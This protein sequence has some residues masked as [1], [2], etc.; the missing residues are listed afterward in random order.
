[1]VEIRFGSH[2]PYLLRRHVLCATSADRDISIR[3]LSYVVL[4]AKHSVVRHQREHDH[5][6]GEDDE[7]EQ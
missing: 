5:I 4:V 1:M 7:H 2:G 6:L 3:Q